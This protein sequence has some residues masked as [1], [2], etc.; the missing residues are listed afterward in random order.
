MCFF[1]LENSHNHELKLP[2]SCLLAVTPDKQTE[3]DKH[4]CEKE[5]ERLIPITLKEFLK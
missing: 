4:H 3:A 2:E 1:L 5:I